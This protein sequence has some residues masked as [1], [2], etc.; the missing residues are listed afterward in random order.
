VAC[1]EA[2][3]RLAAPFGIGGRAHSGD[4]AP[5]LIPSVA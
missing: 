2:L 4:V 1:P 3:V 5:S